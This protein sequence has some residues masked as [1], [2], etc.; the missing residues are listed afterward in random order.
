M[1]KT[2][3]ALF[4]ALT[5]IFL[6]S[7]ALA[8]HPIIRPFKSVRANGMGNVRYTT[9]L[10]EENFYANPARVTANKENQF[11][12]PKFT[13]EVGADAIGSISDLTSGDGLSGLAGHVGDPISAS[14][15]MIF[16]A[17]YSTEFLADFWAF[18]VG[19]MMNSQFVGTVGQTGLISP[20]SVLTA[21]PSFTL[22][23]RLLPGH[24][25]S[26]GINMHTHY[27]VSSGSAIGIS[28]FLSGTG[29]GDT[30]KGGSGLGIDFDAGSTYRAPWELLGFEYNFAFAINNLLGGTYKNLGGQIGDLTNTPLP[31][32]R[33][34]NLG[35]SA[36]RQ[37]SFLDQLLLAIE[38][39]DIGN[40]ENGSLFKTLHLGSEARWKS[41]AARLGVNQGYF[42][43]GLGFDVGFFTM[44][45]ATYGE[46]IGLNAGVKQDRRYAL[47]FGFQI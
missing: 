37:I 19:M 43:A 16:P 25:L 39:T 18:G 45:L 27:R 2:N 15:Q 40:N 31:T 34:F 36:K 17:W 33:S 12:L 26:V 20:V 38:F 30:I 35:A 41:L 5:T 10:Y 4:T 22:G 3:F 21:G 44:N 42:T 14:F 11:Q 8:N 23:R 13:I 7:S 47:D 46:E 29:L 9:G 1:K 6:G 28:D 24:P 32:K